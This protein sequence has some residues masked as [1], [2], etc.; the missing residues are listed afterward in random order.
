M[1][2]GGAHRSSPFYR[3]RAAPGGEP[4]AS[5]R[6]RAGYE[7]LGLFHVRGPASKASYRIPGLLI[8]ERTGRPING[9]PIAS[10]PQGLSKHS[11]KP[12]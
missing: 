11:S 8:M 6:H 5:L 3:V 9:G 10:T 4:F 2:P 7:V 1:L 12:P